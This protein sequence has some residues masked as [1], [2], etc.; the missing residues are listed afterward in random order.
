MRARVVTVAA[1]AALVL[2]LV[3]GCGSDSGEPETETV[4]PVTDVEAARMAET[5]FNDHD[6]GGADFEVNAMMPDGTRI[7]MEG[8]VDW[9][10]HAGH[11]DVQ[12]DATA[13]AAVT[14]VIWTD[15]VVF[16]RIP[17][18]SELA[19][20][21]G[22]PVA[23]FYARPPSIADRHLDA[24]IQLLTSLGTEQR[25]N[26]VLIAQ[27]P[28]TAWLRSDV[29]PG[30]EIAVDVLRY[31]EQ[32]IYWIGEGGVTLYRFEG[33]NS[34]VTRP[35]VIDLRR[36][37]PREIEIPPADDVIESSLIPDLYAAATAD[38]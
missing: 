30:T 25:D 3:T 8:E 1:V 16:E 26:A 27:T 32:T 7:T 33:N 35:V 31:G 17:A 2:V 5:L 23:D 38:R 24:M 12:I 10:H 11:A 36:H 34:S 22:K 13:D 9:V 6:V 4:R 29:V 19:A 37:G 28:G 14:E 18:L 20:A 21:L 15:S